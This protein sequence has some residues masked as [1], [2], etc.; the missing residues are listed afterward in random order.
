MSDYCQGHHYYKITPDKI[1]K[2]GLK[3]HLLTHFQFVANIHND[4]QMAVDIKIVI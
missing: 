2:S 1:I 3:K 4:K